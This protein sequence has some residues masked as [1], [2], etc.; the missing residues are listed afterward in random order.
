MNPVSAIELGQ[1]M[2]VPSGEV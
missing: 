1:I 2:V